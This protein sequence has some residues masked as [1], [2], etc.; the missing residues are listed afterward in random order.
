MSRLNWFLIFAFAFVTPMLGA[1]YIPWVANLQTAKRQAAEQNKLVMVHFYG[2]QCPPCRTLEANVFSQPEV[3][4]VVA[5]A[6]VP[7]KVNVDR[8]PEIARQFRVRQ[9]PT[10]VF[11]TATGQVVH[12]GV[13]PQ[14]RGSQAA[15]PYIQMIQQVA[16]QGRANSQPKA[17]FASNRNSEAAAQLASAG[18][19]R[20][21]QTAPSVGGGDFQPGGGTTE[22]TGG[23]YLPPRDTFGAAGRNDT[24]AQDRIAANREPRVASNPAAP[25]NQWT[26]PNAT[27]QNSGVIENQFV[28]NSRP[29]SA[30]IDNPY[31]QKPAP[32]PAPTQ[33]QPAP[34]PETAKQPDASTPALGG[35]CPVT[36][37]ENRA[38]KK[39]S[40]KFGA[41]HR[42]RLYLF[43]SAE[44]QTK[45]LTDPDRYSP[46]ISGYDPVRYIE[47][48]RLVAGHRKH[49]VFFGDKIY[50]FEEESTM[51]RF[52][53][54]PQTYAASAHQAMLQSPP[55]RR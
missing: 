52:W 20:N 49:G 2:E 28:Q 51:K 37:M 39:A 50:L 47:E 46:M 21:R 10:D 25:Q 54:S 18:Q 34:Q 6:C 31:V 38:W 40:P 13:S 33:Q 41:I 42:G 11:L 55:T 36:L 16:Y 5:A 43:A 4:G 48:G 12:S 26:P 3:G 7:V 8:Q 15:A 29:P 22:P 30:A 24:W 45:F 1:D 23:S 19:P 32:K 44:N 14:G 9:W 17:Q 27:P 53:K 35:Y